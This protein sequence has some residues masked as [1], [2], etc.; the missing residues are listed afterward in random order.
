MSRGYETPTVT[1][2]SFR[3]IP[4]D[5]A[6][7]SFAIGLHVINPNR[8]ALALR[9]AS[10]TISLDGHE[11]V[12]GVANDLPVIAAYGEGSF[13][14]TA[15][16]NLFAGIRLITDLMST[17][18]DAF[19]YEFEAKLDPGGFGQTIRVRDSGQV[20]LRPARQ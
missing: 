7:P 9:G 2:N 14:V 20:S 18:R 17:S 5:G 8:Q 6:I 11:L 19:Q 3:A 13:T 4:S 16:V 10:Y 12:K 1:V 15:S